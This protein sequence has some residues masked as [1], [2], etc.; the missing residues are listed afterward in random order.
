MN[1]LEREEQ[2]LEDD[3]NSGAISLKEL[4]RETRDLHA[5]YREQAQESAQN[6]YD[7]ELDRW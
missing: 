1:Q 5:S 3:Y 6:A 2:A 4:N 7:E